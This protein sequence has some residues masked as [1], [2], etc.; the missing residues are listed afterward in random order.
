MTRLISN[1]PIRALSQYTSL[2]C[3]QFLLAI[4][5]RSPA[6]GVMR[7]TKRRQAHRK[8]S[9][10]VLL[11]HWENGSTLETS[12]FSILFLFTRLFALPSSFKIFWNTRKKLLSSFRTSLQGEKVRLSNQTQA[13]ELERANT[14]KYQDA[15]ETQRQRTKEESNR[16]HEDIETLRR[17]VAAAKKDKTDV[18][19]LL[20]RER[21]SRSTL[22]TELERLKVLQGEALGEEFDL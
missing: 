3:T 22:E 21:I 6:Q 10:S 11:N 13:L 12:G 2:R 17:Q 4:F 19:L 5:D 7:R 8:S 16:L 14:K 15:V 9:F 20:E 1:Q 18:E